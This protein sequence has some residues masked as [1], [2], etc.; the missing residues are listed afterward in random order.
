[1]EIISID[2]ERQR[3]GLSIRRVPQHLRTYEEPEPRA[4][5]ASFAGEAVLEPEELEEPLEVGEAAESEL[6]DEVADVGQV[7]DVL[8][9]EHVEEAAEARYAEE[10]SERGEAELAEQAL[11]AVETEDAGTVEGEE[12]AAGARAEAIAD[13]E[14]ERLDGGDE[15]G[16]GVLAATA[17]EGDGD[18]AIA[19]PVVIEE[20]IVGLPDPEDADGNDA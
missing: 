20:E 6:S 9:L 18:R 15:A 19:E 3:I 8:E 16:P 4:A 2:P 14:P 1:V 5:T 13:V 11:P 17:P 10:R 12:S 7:E